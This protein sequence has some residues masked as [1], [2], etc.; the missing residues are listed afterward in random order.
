MRVDVH[1]RE[2][3]GYPIPLNYPAQIH[4]AQRSWRY[5]LQKVSLAP[6]PNPRENTNPCAPSA[7]RDALYA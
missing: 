5:D 3:I 7:R 2:S 6:N 4:D 1:V